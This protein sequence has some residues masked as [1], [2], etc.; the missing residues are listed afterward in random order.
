MLMEDTFAILDNKVKTQPISIGKLEKIKIQ[1][2]SQ[3]V[4]EKK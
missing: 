2:Y 4:Q 3:Y 1:S